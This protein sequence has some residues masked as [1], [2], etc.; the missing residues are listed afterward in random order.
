VTVWG[1]ELQIDAPPGE[2]LEVFV[3]PQRIRLVAL[4]EA[5]GDDV[6]RLTGRVA[7]SVF[8]GDYV[9]TVVQGA[10][11]ELTV[12]A[13]SGQPPLPDGVEVAAVWKVG[14]MRVFAR[15]TA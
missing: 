11:G 7:R 1:T 6:A 10:D 2:R 12:E 14:D 5:A 9:E 13:P 15:D 8:V 4:S 3:R